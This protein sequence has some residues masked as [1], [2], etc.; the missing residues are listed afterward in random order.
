MRTIVQD[1]YTLAVSPFEDCRVDDTV[2]GPPPPDPEEQRI[3]AQKRVERAKQRQRQRHAQ[4]FQSST[5]DSGNS[6]NLGNSGVEHSI[7]PESELELESES[8]ISEARKLAV[9]CGPRD[10]KICSA[11]TKQFVDNAS[12][13][14]HLRNFPLCQRWIDSAP[15]PGAGPSADPNSSPNS[16]PSA[17]PRL[18]NIANLRANPNLTGSM[19]AMQLGS[20]RRRNT[21]DASIGTG[22]GAN[23]SCDCSAC[24]R[25]FSSP[26][27]L[28]RH[29][30]S[31]LVCDR[32][33][34]S[35]LLESLAKASAQCVANARASDARSGKRPW[36]PGSGVEADIVGQAGVR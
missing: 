30:K 7:E 8:P 23:E 12:L 5:G 20:D 11:C 28:N 26:S 4:L 9:M 16:N 13:D 24:G 34:A 14:R 3:I 10:R 2:Y 6:G 35:A 18:I 22:T 1:E 19:L 27:A 15:A 21:G 25:A 32:M 31:S 33:R 17:E 29:Y 36:G